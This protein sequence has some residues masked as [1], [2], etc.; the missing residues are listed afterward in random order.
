M[1]IKSLGILITY[2]IPIKDRD[3]CTLSS[4]EALIEVHMSANEPQTLIDEYSLPKF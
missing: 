4:I 2:T 3:T 1:T